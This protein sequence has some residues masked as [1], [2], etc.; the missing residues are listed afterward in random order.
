MTAEGLERRGA[1]HLVVRRCQEA[2]ELAL[3]GVLRRAHPDL[4]ALHLS[5][6]VVASAWVTDLA[7]LSLDERGSRGRSRFRAPRRPGLTI[8][9]MVRNG[10]TV[11]ERASDHA[12]SE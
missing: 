8:E 2:V 10:V 6:A 1:W 9:R 7:I 12:R 4:D 3:K 5:S 11:F